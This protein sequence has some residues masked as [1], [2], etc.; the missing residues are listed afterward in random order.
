MGE[1]A[2]TLTQVS[3]RDQRRG[4]PFAEVLSRP[5]ALRFSAAGLIGRMPM[6]MFGLGTLLLI[7]SF[8][9]R[10]GLAGLVAAA[11]SVGYAVCAPQAARLADRFGQARVLRPQAV[12]F[13]ATTIALIGCAEGRAPT[14]A[15][16][17]TG[18][19]AGASMPTLGSMVRARWS[20]LLGDSP[21][22]HSAFSLESVV[23]EVI[24]VIGPA[25]VT[26]LATEVYPASG[27]AV[28]MT[29]CF[30]GTLLFA[31]QRGT[32]PPPGRAAAAGRRIRLPAPGLA[33]L[34]PVHL[35]LGAQFAAVDLSTVDFA[36]QHGHKPLAGFILGT[37]ALG[38][39]A[40]GL[41]YGS[42]TWRAPLHRRFAITLCLVWAGVATFWAMPGLAVLALV[43]FFCGLA[44]SPTLIAGYSLVGQQ[45]AAG[46][47]TEG[48]TWLSSA[49][50]V[51][52]ATGSAVAGHLVDVG[53]A[54]WGYWFAAACGA[55]AV[56]TC[57]LGLR[58]LRMP[59]AA[60]P[61]E[62]ADAGN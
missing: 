57:L 40:G 43:I 38:S 8:T 45:A 53:G 1:V 62:W 19:L 21:L 13:A 10:Y 6:S 41:W 42:R 24:F 59:V 9:G 54:R 14:W 50:S 3:E 20:T 33:T 58:R 49:I 17:L 34:V 52:I 26:V 30:I 56:T 39:A 16:L 11:G 55:G 48:L 32:E 25:L 27:V 29:A 36:Q 12:F 5:G 2:G 46:R 15:L 37:Y 7:A 47:R 44:I 4:N 28:A 35:F 60:E 22:L 61:A 31:A 18:G 23:D 51:G